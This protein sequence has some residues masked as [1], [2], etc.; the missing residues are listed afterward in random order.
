[1][2]QMNPQDDLAFIKKIMQDSRRVIIDDGK[3]FIFWGIFIALVLL[4]NY[5]IVLYKI[6]VE[7]GW[8]YWT[9]LIMVGWVYSF[10]TE[11]KKHKKRRTKTFAGKMLSAVWFSVGVTASIAGLVGSFSGAIDGVYIS[12]VISSIL[13]IGYFLSA[14]IYGYRWIIYIAVGWWL[15][16]IFMFIYPGMHTFL[17][18]VSMLIFLQ[19]IPG[20]I[21]YKKSKKELEVEQNGN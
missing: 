7:H 10:I 3:G 5:F 4:G 14:V 8:L 12:P 21:I 17:V 20:I 15:G 13:G 19:T 2:E 1:M 9:S 6:R 11:Y 16:A 18:M